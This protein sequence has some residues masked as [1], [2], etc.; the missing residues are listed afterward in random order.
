MEEENQ[1]PES[2]RPRYLLPFGCKDLIDVIRLQESQGRQRQRRE[3]DPKQTVPVFATPPVSAPC[4]PQ[5]FPPFV[6]IPDPVTVRDLA[7]A[8][9]L[10]TF[11][12]I[13]ALMKM[14]IFVNPD[15][16]LDFAIASKVCAR[17]GVTD[18]RIS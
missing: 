6:S 17:Y 7:V 9:G 3:E 8:L 11:V 12:I 14:D 13:K 10:K 1:E 4:V 5:E 16:K 18:V 2:E 15:I